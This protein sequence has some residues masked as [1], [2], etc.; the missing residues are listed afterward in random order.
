MEDNTTRYASEW[1]TNSTFGN[2]E[3]IK[4]DSNFAMLMCSLVFAVFWVIYITY[5]NSRVVGFVITK[6]MN[7]F[8]IGEGYFKIGSLSVNALSGKIMFRDVVY[9]THDYTIRVQ[10]GY[11]IFRWWR[12]YVPKDVSEDLSHSD[13]RL[14]VMLNGFELHVYNRSQLYSNLERIF[15]IGPNIIPYY[16]NRTTE[17]LTRSQSQI[18][19]SSVRK[20]RPEAAMAR[21]WRD[22]IPVIKIDVSSS[23]LV[24]GNRLVPTTLSITFEESHFVYSTK[25]AVCTLDRFMHFVKC[26]AENVRVMLAPSPKYTG[27]LDDPPRYMGEG[28]VLMSTNDLEL[29]F[30]MDEPGLVPEEPVLVTL[31]NGDIVESSP[32]QWGVD[33]KAGKGTDFSYGPWADRQREHLFKFF[34]PQDY[35]PMEGTK[36]PKPG[37]KRQMQSFDVRLLMQNDATIDILFTKDKETNAVHINVG[38]GSY[39]EVTLPWITLQDGYSTKINGQLLHLEATTSLQF[40]DFV[41]SETLEFCILCHYPLVWNDHQL[42]EINLTGCKATVKLIFSHKWFFQDLINDWASKQ[43]PD[44]MHFVPYTWRFGLTLKHCEL[45]TLANQYNWIDCSSVGQRTRLENTQLALCAHFLHLSFDL[46]FDEFLP[47]TL[48]LNFSIQG[49]SIDLSLFIPEFHTSRNI[50]QS[51]EKYAKVLSKDGSTTKKTEII[52]KWRNA[53]QNR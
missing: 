9:I 10:D 29:Y 24:F 25:P 48:P 36:M 5:Y 14:S 42:W 43:L 45:I 20:Q 16:D 8:F 21:T 4:M 23:R 19:N 17:S 33:I 47:E 34:Y 27:M 37:E 11:L 31:A 35:V 1:K 3:D 7:R 52:P 49:E 44:L 39:L 6:T 18:D 50:V 53:C 12:S 2:L 40:R 15:G 28:F 38:A 32:P 51:L 13:T 41:E 22:L 46:P 30:Y 26:K